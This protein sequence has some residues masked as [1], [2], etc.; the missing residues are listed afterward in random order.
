MID[1]KKIKTAIK[2]LSTEKKIPEEKVIEIIEAA[3]KTAYKKD[4]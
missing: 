3:L 2:M 1:L 4:Y